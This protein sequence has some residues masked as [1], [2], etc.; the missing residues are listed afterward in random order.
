MIDI[1]SAAPIEKGMISQQ[2][3]FVYP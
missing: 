3:I 1:A 2:M